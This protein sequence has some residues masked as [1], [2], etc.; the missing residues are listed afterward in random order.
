LFGSRLAQQITRNVSYD[1]E[2]GF[3]LPRKEALSEAAPVIRTSGYPHMP[4]RM[5]P[6][7]P[8]QM[9]LFAKATEEV[10]FGAAAA[11]KE[12]NRWKAKAVS[13][14]RQIPDGSRRGLV[15]D[16]H[17]NERPSLDTLE[18]GPSTRRDS[19]GVAAGTD[20]HSERKAV[21]AP[22]NHRHQ[23]TSRA[24]RRSKRSSRPD[25]ALK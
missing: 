2:Y 15:C 22:D 25:M 20:R 10:S 13:L 12:R 17:G 9:T 24:S 14:T 19:N 23:K 18:S 21:V 11:W 6:D 5:L 16:R 4:E 8:Q 3:G 1:T 7:H